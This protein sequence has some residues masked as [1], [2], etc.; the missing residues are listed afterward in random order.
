MP[1]LDTRQQ[2]IEVATKDF[3]HYGFKNVTVDE[4]ARSAGISKKTL[5]QEFSKK[6]DLVLASVQYYNQMHWDEMMQITDQSTNA[7]EELVVTFFHMAKMFKGMNPVCFVDLQRYYSKAYKY[8]E[9][10]KNSQLHDCISENLSRGIQEGFFRENID[11]EIIARYRMESVFM[12]MHLDL[13]PKK[14][15]DLV[16]VSKQTF[17]LYMFGIS[18]LKGHKLI[19]KYLE[20]LK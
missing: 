3:L 17:E 18:T 16:E 2:I 20:N 12:I 8:M 11:T 10:F 13:F 6:D 4:I 1:D 5:Y 9:G 15:F 19:T 14:E 7:I